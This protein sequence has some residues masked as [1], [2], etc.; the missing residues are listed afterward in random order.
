MDAITALVIVVAFVAIWALSRVAG[1]R[2]GGK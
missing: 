1:K 2:S